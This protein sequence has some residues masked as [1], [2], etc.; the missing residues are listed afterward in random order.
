MYGEDIDL[1]YRFRKAGRGIVFFADAAAIHYGGSSSASAPVRFST[2]ML[3]A[4]LQYWRK[5]HGWPAQQL[6]LISLAVFHLG[7]VVGLAFSYLCL[8]AKR[9]NLASKLKRNVACLWWT[10]LAMSGKKDACQARP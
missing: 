6:L 8:P 9:L 4:N 3:R 5:H 2:E 1:C 10:A 7:R